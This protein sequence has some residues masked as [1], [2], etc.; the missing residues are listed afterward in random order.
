[1]VSILYTDSRSR[2]LELCRER[3]TDIT[4]RVIQELVSGSDEKPLYYSRTFTLSKWIWQVFNQ[5]E[6]RN[7]YKLAHCAAFWDALEK[8]PEHYRKPGEVK[9]FGEFGGPIGRRKFA[10]ASD[11]EV[12]MS[13]YQILTMVRKGHATNPRDYVYGLL[14]L[15]DPSLAARI[16]VDYTISVEA[17]YE[18]FAR[19]IIK[20]EESLEILGQCDIFGTP[21][22]VPRMDVNSPWY[23]HIHSEEEEPYNSSGGRNAVCRF[24][25]QPDMT[26]DSAPGLLYTRAILLDQLDGLSTANLETD[27]RDENRIYKG[28]YADRL[29]ET[30]GNSNAYGSEDALK[31]AMWRVVGGNRDVRGAI[32][33]PNTYSLLLS[34][35]ALED[36]YEF[37]GAGAT[38]SP[39]ADWV[40][41]NS[42]LKI[43]GKTLV[44]YFTPAGLATMNEDK[45]SEHINHIS[46]AI[47]RFEQACWSRRIAVTIKGYLCLVPWYAE[48]NDYIAVM[49]GCSFPVLLR[50]TE[51]AGFS[52]EK[53][54]KVVS[55]CYVHGVMEGEIWADL[56]RG[57]VELEDVTLA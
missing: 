12:T 22:W 3:V 20:T 44:E 23:R 13:T 6:R 38:S 48:K 55:P 21:S 25:K 36:Q 1:M 32:P 40:G 28:G 26:A 7:R 19:T 51:D 2:Y 34:S 30:S 18:A 10:F 56:D 54:Y 9:T 47:H 8:H 41:K 24:D 42:K 11:G 46:S 49:P 5:F 37:F 27:F 14:G 33:A 35:E 29:V 15:L 31:E 17:V 57:K 50:S 52:D 43:A 4:Y 16:K 53:V 45:L 39:W